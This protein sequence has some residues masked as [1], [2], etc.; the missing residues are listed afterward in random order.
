MKIDENLFVIYLPP[1]LSGI[2]YYAFPKKVNWMMINFI[3]HLFSPGG[4][5]GGFHLLCY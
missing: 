2:T 3:S 5:A 4:R 1:V